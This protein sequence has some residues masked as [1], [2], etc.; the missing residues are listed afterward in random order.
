MAALSEHTRPAWHEVQESPEP[1]ME[2]K[3]GVAGGGGVGGGGEG[4][5][6]GGGDGESKCGG[7]GGGV[8]EQLSVNAGL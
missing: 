8:M 7:A 6:G 1:S 3:Y 4:V 2:T 5:G